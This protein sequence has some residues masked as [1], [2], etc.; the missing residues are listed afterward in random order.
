M[1]LLCQRSEIRGQ[2]SEV[3]SQ[4]S[5]VRSQKSE[6]R[7]QKSE[8][9]SQKSE[10]RSQKSEVR[11]QKS[12]VRSQKSEVRSQKSEVRSQKSEVRSQKSEVVKTP[13]HINVAA[14]LQHRA[15]RL[16]FVARTTSLAMFYALFIALTILGVTKP[17]AASSWTRQRSGTLS[18]L[19]AVYF[20]DQNHGWIA[21]SN[22][23]VLTT[24][25]GGVNWKITP[26]DTK[27]SLVDI[28]FADE[29]VGWV[30]A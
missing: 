29:R 1:V 22:G 17:A 24:V 26:C 27:D 7:S 9:R 6:V 11:S 25:D 21:G 30:L 10:V 19:H 4:K 18:W 5:E 20:V 23:T 28:Y 13:R 2:R 15:E 14:L 3:R 8:V 12:E 16:L